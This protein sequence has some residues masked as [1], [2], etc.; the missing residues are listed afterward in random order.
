MS[1]NYCRLFSASGFK[2]RVFIMVIVYCENPACT[3]RH[4][5]SDGTECMMDGTCKMKDGKT[6]E[7]KEGAKCYMEGK[8]GR[9]K[10]DKVK[11]LYIDDF[12]FLAAHTPLI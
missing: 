6:M 3:E 4:D 8:M 7:M 12:L 2:G 9:M 10:M 11:D 5:E 1:A